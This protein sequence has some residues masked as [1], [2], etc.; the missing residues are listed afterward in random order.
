MDILN[1]EREDSLEQKQQAEQIKSIRLI[2]TGITAVII[3]LILLF[4]SI[5]TLDVEHAAVITTLGVPKEVTDPGLHFKIPI[6]QSLK[7]VDTT[8]HGMGIGYDVNTGENILSES[9]MISSDYNFLNIDFYLE[10]QVSDAIKF[11]YASDAPISILRSTSQNCIRT[12]IASYD[13]DSI[14]TTGKSEIQS[15]I[16]SM[17]IEKMDQLDIGIT[18]RNITI[19]DSEPPT[20]EVDAAFKS[21]ETA[22]QGKETAVNNANKYR[23]EQ[24]PAAEAEIDRILQNAEAQR[25]QRIAEAQGQVARFNAMY[26][27]YTKYPLITKERMFYE[28]MEEILPGM[29][30]IIQGKDGNVQTVFPIEK[31]SDVT[32]NGQAENAQ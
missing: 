5:Y 6:I 16:K 25:S 22:K 28:A 31:F 30:I 19:Q 21:V 12:V 13:V 10:Y 17:L 3:M 26:E 18:I 8:I 14:L 15:N 20:A 24:L 32:V 2:I 9:V 29:K 1:S 27:E 23:N 11:T 4:S 7:K